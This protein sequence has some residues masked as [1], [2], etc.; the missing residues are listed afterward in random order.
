MAYESMDKT[1][2]REVGEAENLFNKTIAID[3][4]AKIFVIAG[5]S[6][7]LEKPTSDGK[8]WM[9]AVFKEKY[10]IDPFVDFHLLNNMNYQ[11]YWKNRSLKN[12]LFYS[13]H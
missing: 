1:K 3:P 12:T 6:H 9:A 4:N 7:I 13:Y 11:S 10:N 8:K 2:D 5:I